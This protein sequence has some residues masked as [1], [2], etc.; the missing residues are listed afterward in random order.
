MES[1]FNWLNEVKYY[2][3][4]LVDKNKIVG[5]NDLHL[6]RCG[7]RSCPSQQELDVCHQARVPLPHQIPHLI[8][9]Q[10]KIQ[11]S[12]LFS[13]IANSTNFTV[14]SRFLAEFA[15]L[16]DLQEERVLSKDSV[17]LELGVLFRSL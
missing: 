17:S 6:K 12:K 14:F 1:Y 15:V 9:I 13:H 7:T 5:L 8:K 2:L 10:P 3:L 16:S 11:I 4:G